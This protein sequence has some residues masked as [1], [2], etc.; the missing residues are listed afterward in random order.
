MY[1]GRTMKKLLIVLGLVSVAL[2]PL[3]ASPSWIGVQGI[4]SYKQETITSNVVG[5]TIDE[6]HTANLAGL[7]IAG[8]L[9]PGESPIG[10]GFQFGS[11]KTYADKRISSE[12]DVSEYP[13]TWNGGLTGKFRASLT[14]MLALEIGAGLSYARMAQTYDIAGS[15]VIAT[16]N[17]LSLLTSADLVVHLGDKLALVGGVGASFPLNTQATF[18]SGSIEYER[19]LDVKGYT[20]SGQVGVALGF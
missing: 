16:L 8:T 4:G 13:L 5:T 1:E 2:F 6:E 12:M 10:I 15:D 11:V 3:S 14:E 7:Q 19:E 9:Y 20:I 17:T 18:T